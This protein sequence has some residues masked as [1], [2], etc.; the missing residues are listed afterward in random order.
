MHLFLVYIIA[1]V[2]VQPGQ[3]DSFFGI[4]GNNKAV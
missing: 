1:T 2:S 3:F 4:Q